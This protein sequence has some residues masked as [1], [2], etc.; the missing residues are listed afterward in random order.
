MSGQSLRYE[1]VDPRVTRLVVIDVQNDFCDPNGWSARNGNDLTV[2]QKVAENIVALLDAARDAEIQ[3]IFVRAIYDR[4]FLSEPMLEQKR[5]AGLQVDHC[6]SGTWGADFYR[7]QPR[8]GEPVVSKH[9]YSA[10]IDTD[11]NALLRAQGVRNL[12]LTGV[13]TNVCVESTARDAFMLD[14]HVI[15]VEDCTGTYD[16]AAHEAT[17]KNV[18]RFFGHVVASEDLLALWQAGRSA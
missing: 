11:L 3:P 4:E 7:V 15:L 16:D 6:Q 18:D 12:V 5:R 8:P 1:R 17:L 10:F 2:I 9:R 14:Y 13:N